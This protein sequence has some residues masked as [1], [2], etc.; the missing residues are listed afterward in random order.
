MDIITIPV[1]MNATNCYIVEY[2]KSNCIIIDPGAEGEKI[3]TYIEQEQMEVKGIV[4]THGHFDHIGAVKFLLD[5]YDTEL[6]IHELDNPYLMDAR[7]NLSFMIGEKIEL[8]SADRLIDEGDRYYDF[9]VIATPGHTPGGISL[10]NE[11]EGIL[12]SG[13]TIFNSGYGRTD[14]PGADPE[15]LSNSIKKLLLLPEKTKIFPGHGRTTTIADFRR[16]IG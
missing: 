1:G 15:E 2:K 3:F 8:D 11:S 14:F 13:D 9:K 5:Q 10:Y 6:A 12:F 4:L 16:Y 7:K